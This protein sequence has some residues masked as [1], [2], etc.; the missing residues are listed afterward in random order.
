MAFDGIV[1]KCIVS[2]LNE[3]VINSKVN[4]IFE[5]TKN[6]I[7]LGLY[8]SGLNYCLHICINPSTCRLNLTT[9]SKPN[10]LTAPNFCMLLRK[11]LI[12]ARI[13]AIS[14]FD[15][16]RIVEI[17]F[18]CYNELND[19]I[20][21][22]AASPNVQVAPQPHESMKLNLVAPEKS[23]D[24][25]YAIKKLYI[26]IM[27]S[28]SNVILT[29]KDNVIIDAIKHISCNREI[30]PARIYELP[31]NN[32]NSILRIN[33]FN[34][35]NSII[36]AISTNDSLDKKISDSFNGLCRPFIQYVLNKNN[37]D[38]STSY[39]FIKSIIANIGTNSLA[40]I[41]TNNDYVI[42]FSEKNGENLK[43][44]FFIDDYYYNKEAV[45][46]FKGFRNDI[47][48]VVLSALK[49]STKK[50]DNINN[51]LNECNKMDEYK[52]F[53]ELI[54]SNLYR[55]KDNTESAT[56]ENYYNNNSPITIPLDKSI[57]PNKNAEKYFRKYNKLKNTLE[58]VSMQ[59]RE[60]E[61]ELNYIESIVYSIEN[62]K[63]ISDL[64]DIFDEI[65]G[66][67]IAPKNNKSVKQKNGRKDSSKD[68]LLKYEINGFTVL[69]GKNNRQ[70][71]ELTLKIAS[72]DD[73]WF[74]TQGIHG[75]HVILKTEGKDIDENT[76]F[77]C[78]KLAA[79]HSKAK[80]SSNVPVDYCLVKFVKKPSSA[81]PGMVVYTNYKTLYV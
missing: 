21:R 33:S 41:K 78:A 42:D 29:N 38:L 76:I 6:D 1:T 49:K 45:N 44:N 4:K 8:N 70:N 35:F 66:N 32:K 13:I 62:A 37:N 5:P 15:L 31:T 36:S 10:P 68:N 63:N 24:F 51:K 75:S 81:K 79:K 69:V 2:E 64:E 60:T 3:L 71:D 50:L 14:S 54:T 40:C 55:L 22:K 53:G 26:E 28:C 58:I 16:D 20:I 61:K 56:L 65:S 57:S 73:Y 19:K 39:K 30:M 52:L 59:K 7:M 25:S 72:K 48:K 18:E 27:G 43:V 47:L 34:E 46:S 9:H 80:L 11:H 17:D 74:H 67:L 77:E 23:Y 12:G